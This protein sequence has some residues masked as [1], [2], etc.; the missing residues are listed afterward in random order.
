MISLFSKYKLVEHISEISSSLFNR[1]SAP[2]RSAHTD[3]RFPDFKKYQRKPPLRDNN[4]KEESKSGHGLVVGLSVIA[5]IYSTKAVAHMFVK[6]MAISA[7]V[8]AL[9]KV[10]IDLAEIAEG[11]HTTIKWRGKPLFLKHRLPD[12]INDCR[13]TPLS[14]LRDPQS[15]EERCPNPDWLVTIGVCTH[16]GCVPIPNSG[17]YL[18]GYYCPCHGSHYDAA[19]RIRKGPAPTNLEIPVHEFL[20]DNKLIV[21]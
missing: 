9:A 2:P 15:D 19:G 20:P 5:G 21:G 3:I 7:D 17:D 14:S 4:A 6:S 10:E 13:A 8:Q 16:L 11:G 12:E 18:G 1:L